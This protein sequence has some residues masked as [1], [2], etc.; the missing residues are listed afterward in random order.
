MNSQ[1]MADF[2]AGSGGLD[3]TAVLSEA[4]GDGVDVTLIDKRDAFFG[5][6]KQEAFEALA[7]R[8]E[9]VEIMP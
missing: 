3:L 2:G 7:W 5:F 9:R 1:R 8:A 6:S 4:L